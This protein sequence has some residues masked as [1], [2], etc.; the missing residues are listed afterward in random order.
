M[1]IGQDGSIGILHQGKGNI[2]YGGS[3]NIAQG[4][5]LGIY[6]SVNA[7]E[8]STVSSSGAWNVGQSGYGIYVEDK[9][10]NKT[11][12]ITVTNSAN[13]TLGKSALGIYASGN[14]NIT[15]SG[16]IY[17]GIT[18]FGG[19]TSL[20]HDETN[21]HLNS[22]GI[23]LE[24]GATATNTGILESKYERSLA[25]YAE[26]KD[27]QFINNN[28]INIDN[29]AVG[30]LVRNEAIGI[31][32]GTINIGSN[33][34][35]NTY[36][37]GMAAYGKAQIINNGIINVGHG[38]GMLIGN[39]GILENGTT[40]IITVDNG[41]GIQGDGTV[42]NKGTII[43]LDGDSSKAIRIGVPDAEVG[44]VRIKSTGEVYV[45]NKY[46]AI[47]GTLY[48]DG[49]IVVDGAYVDVTTGTP[50]F[51][52]KSVTGFVNILPNFALTGNGKTYKIENFLSTAGTTV[53]GSKIKPLM[54]NLFVGKVT[55]IGE[56]IIV[57][58]PYADLTMGAKFDTLYDQWDQV[59]DFVPYGVDGMAL[60]NL[61]YYLTGIS[62]PEFYTK[63]AA[64]TMSETRGDIY[65]TI[66]RRMQN[67]QK[68]FDA[69]FD[70]ML[71]SHNF[72]RDTGK[73]SVMYRTGNYEDSTL[74]IDD[75]DYRVTGLM[76]MKDYD[77]MRYGNKYGYELGFAVSRFDFDDGPT[78]GVKSKEDVYSLRAGIHGVIS[79]SKN[80]NVRLISRLELGYNRHVAKR[81]LEL[82]TLRENKGSYDT[83]AVTL[84]NKLEVTL[85]R[86]L[87]TAIDGYV[88]LNAEYGYLSN[89]SESL[90]SNGGLTL[91]VKDN[92]YFSVQPEIGVKASRRVYLGK[93]LS[94]KLEGTLAYAYELGE[95]YNGN[96]VRSNSVKNEWTALIE[97]E[98]EKGMVKG[99]IA[100]S[101]E[102]ADHYGFTV[103]VESNKDDSKREGDIV[104]T[105][106]FN[107][108]FL[109][110]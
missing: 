20:E 25:V 56:L 48:T 31:N 18:D 102:R 96:K 1:N 45:N 11:G 32:N 38:I 84:D 93:K 44:A 35:A 60:K 54:G 36:N 53:L 40:G 2:T 77:G 89:F 95:Y 27:T 87:K 29:G 72:T 14:I 67:I 100:V 41:I 97:P 64:R 49:M 12:S 91:N 59:L 90:G 24:K 75:Y 107:Y 21:L 82:E 57:K 94:L 81:K 51:A 104:Y 73:Y 34:P 98:K 65:A 70:E 66:Q 43:V 6:Q 17:A 88:A 3:V 85:Y 106:R 86:G 62:D 78:Y 71:Y 26:G 61:N 50:L 23:F 30:M 5:S 110:K 19:D 37:V 13:I 8:T 101:L 68:A 7:S 63:E 92:D 69:S 108:K 4:G 76:Y 47:G 46:T 28:I 105:I 58:R 55:D 74:G 109:G 39:F 16:N 42:V 15:N 99:K 83:Y 103:E 22:V 80:N 33:Q 10:G 9:S 52:A 79:F